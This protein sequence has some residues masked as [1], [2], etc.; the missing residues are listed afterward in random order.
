MSPDG[1]D[2][3]PGDRVLIYVRVSRLGDRAD[4]LISDE[5]QEAECR[6]WALSEGLVVVG[7]PITDIDKSGREMTK[8]Q[9]ASSIERVRNGEAEGIVVWKFSRWG[10]NVLDALQS[11]KELREAGGFIGSAS[12]PLDAIDTPVGKFS[13]SLLLSMAEMQSGEMGKV[14]QNIHDYRRK[15]GLPHSGGPRFGYVKKEDA[16]RDDLPE[17]IYTVDPV[18]GPWLKKA[19]EEVVAGKTITKMVFDLN[20]HGV[21]TTAGG[22][23][24]SRTLT[25]VLDSGFGAGLI[26]DRRGVDPNTDNP[27]IVSYGDGAQKAVIAPEVWDAYKKKRARKVAPRE[28]APVTR[29]SG[30]LYCGVCHRKLRIFWSSS[31]GRR[32]RGFECGR[33]KHNNGVGVLCDSPVTIR[34]SIAEDSL[35]EWLEK[36]MQE[37]GLFE[38][39]L[40]RQQ[41]HD[42]A[43]ANADSLVAEAAKLERQRDRLLTIFLA[44]DSE[45]GEAEESS[46]RAAYEAKHVELSDRIRE[47]KRQASEIRDEA[48]AP[49]IPEINAFRALQF[50]WDSGEPPMVVEML[51]SLVSRIY[52]HKVDAVGP[53]LTGRLDV[54]GRWSDDPY[55][56]VSGEGD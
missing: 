44:D 33:D 47:L 3:R 46:P 2:W 56:V 26:I 43:L 53:S 12:E 22:R 15:L 36:S 52:V 17:S 55:L 8:R 23:W 5:I 1:K 29:L 21:L 19:Y 7:H 9:I 42:R 16:A 27:N 38:R 34:Q 28:A 24:T 25:K 32:F 50:A 51:R 45:P 39:S 13:L 30:L 40:E 48:S 4:S 54:I 11:L 6:R 37:D 14:W 41:S 20:E 35:R 10:R 18:T 49:R 31:R